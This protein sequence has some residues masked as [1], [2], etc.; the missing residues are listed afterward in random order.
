MFIIV[1]KT[2]LL[3]V[4]IVQDNPVGTHLFQRCIRSDTSL[5]EQY[6][7]TDA[8]ACSPVTCSP[9][10]SKSSTVRSACS[11]SLASVFARIDHANRPA[12]CSRHVNTRNQIAK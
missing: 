4:D 8:I 7:G 3:P 6:T 11:F 5:I 12:R 2:F 9:A 1:N 10:L